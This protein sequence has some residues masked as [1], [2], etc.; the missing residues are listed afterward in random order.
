MTDTAD[1]RNHR[2]LLSVWGGIG[3][4]VMALPMIAA[5]R[6][7]RPDWHIGV[8]VQQSDMLEL[9]DPA[10]AVFR[11][12]LDQYLGRGR[13]DP[14]ALAVSI[15]RFRADAAIS[16]VV[17]PRWRS[18]L[19]ALASGAEIRICENG[20]PFCNRPVARKERHIVMRN[21]ALLQPLGVEAGRPDHPGLLALLPTELPEP[22]QPRI[23]LFPGAGHPYRRW[24]KEGFTEVGKRLSPL[25]E[26]LVFA[27]PLERAL[28]R[29]IAAA[30]GENA[31]LVDGP[32]REKLGQLRSCRLYIGADTGLTHAAAAMGVPTVALLGPADPA[33]YGP[34]GPRV[35]VIRK[36]PP[37][38]PCYK[39]GNRYDCPHPVRQCMAGITVQQVLAAV[40]QTL[41]ASS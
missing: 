39:G 19:L 15:R 26:I 10:A 29:E 18:G 34:L 25:H 27:G 28:S 12:G 40:D 38:A 31:R 21:I 22:R 35:T 3:N 23:G 9:L 37:C 36:Q 33:E 41:T 32:L 11:L 16:S 7:Q 14:A 30:I 17:F 24:H 8:T 6:R 2:V 1:K 4:M 5:L 20:G 13:L